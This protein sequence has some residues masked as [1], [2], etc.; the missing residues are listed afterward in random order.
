MCDESLH[1]TSMAGKVAPV[2]HL[3]GAPYDLGLTHGTRV[4]DDLHR[5]LSVWRSALRSRFEPPNASPSD[6][7]SVD[8]QG[9]I[10]WMNDFVDSFLAATDYIIAIKRWTPWLLDEVRGMATGANVRFEELLTFQLM[11][12]YW[13]HGQEICAAAAHVSAAAAASVVASDR[14]PICADSSMESRWSCLDA[15]DDCFP[16]KKACPDPGAVSDGP[17]HCTSVAF[18]GRS[19]IPAVLAQ[20]MDLES[21]RDGYQIVMSVDDSVRPSQLVFSHAGMIG[22][23]G[24]N[25]VGI[26]V[27]VNNLPQLHHAR[28]G[29]PVAFLI[30]GILSQPDLASARSFALHVPHASG[31]SYSICGPCGGACVIE[32]CGSGAVL[33]ASLDTGNF[34]VHSNHPLA[35]NLYAEEFAK[36]LLSAAAAGEGV[37]PASTENSRE[38]YAAMHGFVSRNSSQVETTAEVVDMAKASLR[39]GSTGSPHPV[40][41]HPPRDGSPGGMSIGAC[42]LVSGVTASETPKMWCAAGPADVNEYHLFE[43][44]E[45]SAKI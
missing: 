15:R 13:F 11:D 16:V 27:V 29:L 7:R 26:G 34:A 45:P 31:Q 33:S 37:G 21:F 20:N 41:R 14:A 6:A 28:G 2:L 9:D 40:C 43:F 12:E 19:G 3:T 32:G 30:R 5:L 18:A 42:V 10:A 38:R 22:L 23:L 1:P 8:T 44:H 24:I 4:R 17:E 25:R 36:E 35:S 39:L